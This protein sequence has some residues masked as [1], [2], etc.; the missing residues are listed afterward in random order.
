M[1]TLTKVVSVPAFEPI[2]TPITFEAKP[3]RAIEIDFGPGQQV[4]IVS[5]TD[6]ISSL[7]AGATTLTAR[8]KSLSDV[9]RSAGYLTD[10]RSTIT[11]PVYDV[12]DTD[13]TLSDFFATKAVNGIGTLNRIIREY[14]WISGN[15]LPL[16]DDGDHQS[17]A[18]GTW[19]FADHTSR[20]YGTLV[21]INCKDI[22]YGLDV[23]ICEPM[24]WTIAEGFGVG[25]PLDPSVNNLTIK[26]TIP[27]ATFNDDPSKYWRPFEHGEHY[28]HE[29]GQTGTYM[30]LESRPPTANGLPDPRLAEIVW[31]TSMY[32]DAGYIKIDVLRARLLTERQAVEISDND[33]AENGPQLLEWIYID[34]TV[35]TMF[36][37]LTTGVAGQRT[38]PSH[39]H[40]NADTRWICNSIAAYVTD[41]RLKFVNPGAV[42]AMAFIEKEVLN[43]YPAVAPVNN[44]GQL[45]F[46]PFYLANDFMEGSSASTVFDE[47]NCVTNKTI[48]LIHKKDQ[49]AT[50]IEIK[51]NWDAQREFFV[52]PVKY[53]STESEEF[54]GFSK[55][56][57]LELLGLHNGV[58]TPGQIQKLAKIYGDAYFYEMQE[59][60][61]ESFANDI[62]LG[63]LVHVQFSTNIVM[64]DANRT[65]S[66]APLDRVMTVTA[67]TEIRATR[68]TRYTLHGTQRYASDFFDTLESHNLS[69]AEYKRGGIDIWPMVNSGV[70]TLE[71]GKKY[72]YVD[73]ANPGEGLTVDENVTVNITGSGKMPQIW[74][75]GYLDWTPDLDF[76]GLGGN[77]GSAGGD[78][79]TT[80]VET[81][82]GVLGGRDSSVAMDVNA[83]HYLSENVLI[84][85][86]RFRVTSLPRTIQRQAHSRIPSFA[87]S[88]ND[89]HLGG[90]P[91]DLSGMGGA[92]A[93]VSKLTNRVQYQSPEIV[94]IQ[95]S[96]GGSGGGSV[97]FVCWSMVMRG[98]ITT[99]GTDAEPQYQGFIQGQEFKGA[100]GGGGSAG[101]LLIVVDGVH[102]VPIINESNFKAFNGNGSLDGRT[103]EGSVNTN[104]VI[105]PP[106]QVP[107][108]VNNWNALHKIVNT[109]PI[110]Y[111]QELKSGYISS[112]AVSRQKDGEIE[113]YITSSAIDP[114]S[115][116]LPGDLGIW[117]TQLSDVSNE[118]PAAAWIMDDDFIYQPINWNTAPEDY[119]TLLYVNRA[120]GGNTSI[121]SDTRPVGESVG[122]HWI[123]SVTGM[124]WILG[125]T[126]DDDTLFKVE[127]VGVSN[128]LV[129]D[130]NFAMSASGHGRWCATRDDALA[131]VNALTTDL[132]AIA[133][134]FI[135]NSRLEGEF[136]DPV[137]EGALPPSA[138]PPPVLVTAQPVSS[139][140]MIVNYMNPLDTTRIDFHEFTLNGN[141][142]ATQ[143]GGSGYQHTGLVLNTQYTVGVRNVNNDGT[144]SMLVEAVGTTFDETG[145]GP[146]GITLTSSGTGRIVSGNAYQDNASILI[147]EGMPIRMT[148]FNG[149][150]FDE[151]IQ[152]AGAFSFTVP[153][154]QDNQSG[155]AAEMFTWNG[156][157]ETVVIHNFTYQL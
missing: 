119:S 16:D 135:T 15:D 113:L 19:L 154:S 58:H 133:N 91:A 21:T 93:P 121:L 5:H 73:D 123:N 137:V 103:Q 38:L 126:A 67:A 72:Y 40:A 122:T 144:T 86:Q 41:L 82:G 96:A 95:G 27:V 1:A 7:P 2:R 18:K 75:Y 84:F 63:T 79:F 29:S 32:E 141:V 88:T 14:E 45:A 151:Q 54:N 11:Q 140:E 69:I 65:T 52:T 92:G 24:T 80:P 26:T 109:P 132:Q 142:V 47:T 105:S 108:P 56:K 97:M 31:A 147:L 13:N 46:K 104:G 43:A 17:L 51:Y 78:E 125:A 49:I 117:D 87:L 136:V 34:E 107:T 59:I 60:Q 50:G 112:L 64:N 42:T 118:F 4:W 89:G 48:Q 85:A 30:R 131:P 10:G 53:V 106:R 22:H 155:L 127:G 152:A 62:E 39:W 8:L 114:P 77:P 61:I 71:M 111:R 149:T 35:T 139:T 76:T 44:R 12:I 25:D 148:L 143:V 99:S 157:P 66:A 134:A 150:Y 74:C 90:Y 23:E 70:V 101:G 146:L 9:S 33:T 36:R 6:S 145:T 37:A 102:P 83:V 129:V 98:V 156:S 115:N 68:T 3:W 110:E 55:T 138:V 116:G 128:D 57:T 100:R 153:S 20:E 124:Q 120:F 81:S 130:G 94:H 28:H